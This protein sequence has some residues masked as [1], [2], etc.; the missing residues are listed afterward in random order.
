MSVALLQRGPSR[1]EET[2]YLGRR[3]SLSAHSPL[4]ESHRWANHS[5]L[6]RPN[7]RASLPSASSSETL[8]HASR[9]LPPNWP[10]QPPSL[11]SSLPSGSWTTPSSETF[12]LITIFPILGSFL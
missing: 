5:S 3:F 9:S 12:V 4:R 11:K 10:N 6:R 8:A 2:T 7:S 1:V